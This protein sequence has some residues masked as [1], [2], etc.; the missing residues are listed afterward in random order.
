MTS[1]HRDRDSPR[2]H[3]ASVSSSTSDLPQLYPLCNLVTDILG[4]EG[5]LW[6]KN[7]AVLQSFR[8]PPNGVEGAEEAPDGTSLRSFVSS[9]VTGYTDD[10][11][12]G[13][14]LHLI[15]YGQLTSTIHSYFRKLE[16]RHA[17]LHLTARKAKHDT[18]RHLGRSDGDPSSDPNLASATSVLGAEIDG[19]QMELRDE[20]RLVYRCA[21]M[22]AQFP[23]LSAPA[24][25]DGQSPSP[26]LPP[27]PAKFDTGVLGSLQDSDLSRTAPAE[28]SLVLADKS[29]TLP[30]RT[31]QETSRGQEPGTSTVSAAPTSPDSGGDGANGGS[32]GVEEVNG[33]KRPTPSQPIAIKGSK[34]KSKSRSSKRS[35]VIFSKLPSLDSDT[36]DE[37]TS[38]NALKPRGSSTSSGEREHPFPPM[39]NR[40]ML[41]GLVRRAFNQ[42]E[43]QQLMFEQ[44]LRQEYS[45]RSKGEILAKELAGQLQVLEN[46]AHPFYKPK[47][48]VTRNGYD[49]WLHAEK[50]RVK[51]LIDKFWH[52][53]LPRPQLW[54]H[55]NP[56][57]Y[58]KAYSTLLQKVISAES[59]TTRREPVHSGRTPSSPLSP[60][61]HRLLTEFGLRYGVGELYRRIVYLDYL[62]KHFDYEMWYIRHCTEELRTIRVLLPRNRN[63]ITAVR[64]EMEML[65]STVHLLH[66]QTDNSLTRIDR[67]FMDSDPKEG[68]ASL[69]ELLTEVLDAEQSLFGKKVGPVEQWLK[70][71]LKS[72]FVLRYER[73]KEIASDET[74]QSS[75]AQPF[76]LSSTLVN[77]LLLDTRDEVLVYRD[78]YQEVFRPYF[79]IVPF[80]KMEFYRLLCADACSMCTRL[81]H[82]PETREG[83]SLDVI[84]LMYRLNERDVE[85]EAVISPGLQLWR[86]HFSDLALVW[87]E[88]LG[89][90][91]HKWVVEAVSKDQW[92]L[93]TFSAHS[94]H[95]RHPTPFT[96]ST[97]I[98]RPSPK[99]TKSIRTS[100]FPSP[101]P[102]GQERRRSAFTPTPMVKSSGAFSPYD[103]IGQLVQQV[104]EQPIRASP[105][106]EGS[107]ALTDSSASNTTIS[108]DSTN[109]VLIG[110]GIPSG[111]GRKLSKRTNTESL[112]TFGQEEG[113]GLVEN[114][115]SA[116]HQIEVAVSVYSGAE[117][118]QEDLS[119]CQI[120]PI[121]PGSDTPPY[122][123]RSELVEQ[124]PS[125][126]PSESS[127]NSAPTP[128][129]AT[130][131]QEGASLAR[132]AATSDAENPVL[133]VQPAA[134]EAPSDTSTVSN[135][136]VNGVHGKTVP[137]QLTVVRSQRLNSSSTQFGKFSPREATDYQDSTD[138]N[139]SVSIE[140]IDPSP[141]VKFGNLLD[142]CEVGHSDDPKP[143]PRVVRPSGQ[144]IADGDV[145][146]SQWAETRGT[147]S[148]DELHIPPASVRTVPELAEWWKTHPQRDSAAID[149]HL[150][151][152]TH[153]PHSS[154]SPELDCKPNDRS[155]MNLPTDE[156]DHNTPISS[157]P[158]SRGTF[159]NYFFPVSN[160]PVDIV[161]MLT[162]LA[163]FTGT[164]LNVLTPRLPRS[165]PRTDNNPSHEYA[166]E[167]AQAREQ[168]NLLWTNAEQ[169]RTEFLKKMH[170]IMLNA[171]KLY[172]DNLLCM[173]LCCFSG[174]EAVKLVGEQKLQDLKR[175]QTSG[176]I[177]G[178]RHMVEAR[179][180][181][182][183]NG[184]PC[185][186][187]ANSRQFES[188]TRDMCI[189]I[190]NMCTL[191]TTFPSLENHLYSSMRT[192]LQPPI[193]AHGYISSDLGELSPRHPPKS[194]K[195]NP[196][197]TRPPSHTPHNDPKELS[198]IPSTISLGMGPMEPDE[199]RKKEELPD[200][201]FKSKESQQLL[202][203]LQ[204]IQ[205]HQLKLLCLRMNMFFKP[206]LSLLLEL[207]LIDY[208]IDKRLLPLL[209]F[210]ERHRLA[211]QK[212][213]YP[214][215][216]SVTMEYLWEYI[217]QDL[218]AEAVQ[219]R[220]KKRPV[221]DR[222]Q[223]LLQALS[224]LIET[225]HNKNEGLPL[226][227]L[228]SSSEYLL[229]LLDIMARSTD[230]LIVMFDKLCALRFPRAH[231]DLSKSPVPVDPRL[232]HS[233]RGRLH[234]YKKCFSG[235]EFVERVLEIGRQ[236]DLRL[237]TP[238]SQ[239]S[240]PTH[241][242]GGAGISS[243]GRPVEYTA[244]YATEL[245]QYLL[246]E[247]ILIELPG[248]STLPR[249]EAH[250]P[251][252]STD[253]EASLGAS[254]EHHDL[255][256]PGL[257][258]SS[259]SSIHS[260][261]RGRPTLERQALYNS[262]RSH[263]SASNVAAQF[264]NSGG[265][266]YKFANSED[267]ATDS[268]TLYQSNILAASSVGQT[269]AT[270]KTLNLGVP[271]GQTMTN[272]G[273]D[274]TLREEN[275]EFSNARQGTL[276]LV[277][278]LLV[279]RSRKERRVKQLLQLP[280]AVNVAEQKRRRNVNCDFIF[281]M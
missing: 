277:Y 239:S 156:F 272:S 33:K 104:K 231:F 204:T 50:E 196:H 157:R 80:A 37:L 6:S 117:S 262:Y 240:T 189:R 207:K 224:I 225:M 30:N 185:Q 69:I 201:G 23:M 169:N 136:S 147:A 162:R 121:P 93:L 32:E 105:S 90:Q 220:T 132:L 91:V 243:S 51:G 187:K 153:S 109:G 250:T 208:P 266:F 21:L 12:T 263:R 17:C 274:P 78:K 158:F 216:F 112:L 45:R 144:S 244:R 178:C 226:D 247:A 59:R 14:G 134:G 217:L 257:S 52:F 206:A 46:N 60:T 200:V 98:R 57:D 24:P 254:Y 84:G 234:R 167:V 43:E 99:V 265:V 183:P 174:D 139:P 135:R 190:N 102:T 110:G 155:S 5:E 165:N 119:L 53:S 214:A 176:N 150:R 182:H 148:T 100:P 70:R 177:W 96:P 64:R 152:S 125:V 82:R 34:T 181:M 245:A 276:F 137:P 232:L 7:E 85:W 58:H 218:E 186:K 281:R 79:D 66:G 228:T 203:Y 202:E 56:T 142:R 75:T 192:S 259:Q 188:I 81:L 129:S 211:L 171:L 253:D 215:C 10:T 170:R 122:R 229:A 130:P 16:K 89:K 63:K 146:P 237:E 227:T 97:P 87:M 151:A 86:R 210:L 236:Y 1:S 278:D 246:T 261:R 42:T 235:K 26:P 62:A 116:F 241:L 248:T 198:S 270:G 36:E 166:P 143:K 249:E 4:Q 233:L 3:S 111:F 255:D 145:H 154:A 219:L 44:A 123:D 29:K 39:V 138:F 213:L 19:Q 160:S 175:R 9:R 68:V 113:R 67:L 269:G 49:L 48:F 47:F 114:P 141:L 197:S 13:N 273:S 268:D 95:T 120:S 149:D 55:Y 260:S 131:P 54:R 126:Q 77:S 164:I 107:G 212:Y 2:S 94:P 88:V 179:H 115:E 256:D 71:Y 180:G 279:Q 280:K 159:Q 28:V 31:L 191:I 194:H 209:T 238:S 11:V 35:S 20:E 161:T 199:A 27:L 73:R 275:N 173:D 230:Q 251:I 72:G 252:P 222:A 103:S 223:M 15:K 38:I 18:L 8:V 193:T 140:T 172:A 258:S 41:C 242:A 128:H 65:R 205:K 163:S 40:E 92:T 22:C 271:V 25:P 168:A 264:S 267:A 101:N 124:P 127:P 184:M 83:L 221:T 118:E 61:A 133:E 195:P 76:V 106:E 108:L 74:V